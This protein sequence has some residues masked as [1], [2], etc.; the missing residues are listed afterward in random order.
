M[1]NHRIALMAV[2]LVG[3][4]AL[5]ASGPHSTSR[6]A[7]SSTNVPPM[8]LSVDPGSPL[9][10]KNFNPFSPNALWAQAW[11]YETL[12][13]VDGQTGH[14]TPWLATAYKWNN[15]KELTFTIRSGVKWSNGTPFTAN[16][17]AF[18]F[19]LLKKFP[20][21]DTNGIWASLKSVS[22]KANTVV[23]DFKQPNV[24]DFNYIVTTPIVPASIWSKVKNPVTWTDPNPV[25]TGAY[26]LK[27]YT[28]QEYVLVKNPHYWQ[29]NKVQVQEIEFPAVPEN[30]DTVWLNLAEGKYTAANAFAPNINKIYLSKDPKYR[31]IW[32]APGGACNL[33]MNL[34]KAPFNN[35]KFRQALAYAIDKPVVSSKGEYG[36]EPPASQTGLMLPA[37]KG[38]LDKALVSQYNYH[39]DPKKAA[40]LLKEG[41]FTKNSKG[42]L[43]D[44]GKPI[45]FTMI[46]PTGFSDWIEDSSIIQ[47]NLKQLGITV[48]V[49]T[50]SIS[51]WVSDMETGDFDMTLNFG[52]NDFNPYFYYQDDLN[53]AN[54]APIGKVA[55]SNY[56]R[57]DNS[58]VNALLTQYQQSTSS[59]AQHR[60][61]DQ[62]EKVMLTQVP[63]I[64]MF[65][66][67]NWNEY[68]TRYY[69]GW[70]T[71]S[72]PYAVPTYNTPDVEME[73]TH[74]RVRK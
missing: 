61:I 22:A 5:A 42:Q 6:A 40:Q 59:S 67:A 32:F 19:N 38:Y 63:V 13:Y 27:S 23:F 73:F 47:S 50:P 39:Y 3:A 54:S 1:K 36:Y 35:V 17:V 10:T 16:D 24:P 8:V 43:L 68:D 9:Y 44:H 29:A 45:V 60:I 49:Q 69:V 20:A 33:L 31:H 66:A 65:Y 55:T 28:P 4:L 56:E 2:P 71:A 41:G 62:L 18:T 12:Y 64:P 48:N 26:L 72:N 25:G 15:P 57:Y 34:T 21:L 52:L 58:Q 37:N 7:S 70:P 11:I 46:V 74:L 30:A 53:S 14:Q 51:T